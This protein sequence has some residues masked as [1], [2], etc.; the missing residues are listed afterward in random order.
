MAVRRVVP[1]IQSKAAQE[2]REFYGLLGFEEVMNHGW[3]MTLASP[4]SPAA[5][6]SVMTSDK[7]APVAP[8]MSVEVDDVDAAYAVMRASGAEIIHP[9]QDEEWGVWRF[10]VRDPS[11]LVVNVLGHR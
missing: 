8:V 1:N 10:F 7:T 6:I 9:L 11:G 2:S 5:Q 3:I 4:S